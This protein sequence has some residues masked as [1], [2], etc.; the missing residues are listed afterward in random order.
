MLKAVVWTAHRGQRED[1]ATTLR[2]RSTEEG[3]RESGQYI[4]R[5]DEKDR[6]RAS[7]MDICVEPH[8]LGKHSTARKRKLTSHCL[9]NESFIFLIEQDASR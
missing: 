5:V 8:R 3:W 2:I 6:S 7:E 4:S 1:T 9:Q